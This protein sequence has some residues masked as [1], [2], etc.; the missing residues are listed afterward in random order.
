MKESQI[1]PY[2]HSDIKVRLLKLYLERYINILS[3]SKRV[4]EVDVFD[5]FCGEGIYEN[6]KQGSPLIILKILK[7]LQSKNRVAGKG[8]KFNT[9]FNDFDSAK[10]KKLSNHVEQYKLCESGVRNQLI[11]LMQ[12]LIFQKHGHLIHFQT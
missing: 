1:K 5:V 3:L 8:V 11:Q 2:E 12:R 6:E 7:E 4:E 10:I 9:F